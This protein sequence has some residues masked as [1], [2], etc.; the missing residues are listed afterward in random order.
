MRK[1]IGVTIALAFLVSSIPANAVVCEGWCYHHPKPAGHTFST[2]NPWWAF[3]CPVGVVSAAVVAN[4][5]NNRELTTQEAWTCGL[6][7]W[8]NVK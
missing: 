8:P 3:V 7:Y 6:L 4:W 5:R 1:L 2:S